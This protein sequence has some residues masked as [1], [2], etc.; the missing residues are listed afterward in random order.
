M[1]S[2][3][4]SLK[5]IEQC[6]LFEKKN[7]KILCE[8]LLIRSSLYITFTILL[9]IAHSQIEITNSTYIFFS[10]DL[11]LGLFICYQWYT[12]NKFSFNDIKKCYMN[13]KSYKQYLS[14]K[15]KL[16]FNENY[17]SNISF[18]SYFLIFVFTALYKHLY[19]TCIRFLNS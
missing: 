17:K 11:I 4:E 10:I 14:E 5:T 13:I 18:S 7:I 2:P 9:I 16:K 15:P 3:T 1:E 8:N 19:L 6:T 12:S